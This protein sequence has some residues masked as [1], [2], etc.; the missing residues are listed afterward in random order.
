[1]ELPGFARS[2]HKDLIVA[3]EEKP[4]VTD[5]KVPDIMKAVSKFYSAEM[6]RF[7]RN[8]GDSQLFLC[9]L[10]AEEL[11][12][13]EEVCDAAVGG[14]RLSEAN[15]GAQMYLSAMTFGGK[16]QAANFLK[17]LRAMQVPRDVCWVVLLC[18]KK[19]VCQ[20]GALGHCCQVLAFKQ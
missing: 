5:I 1:M 10:H 3:V 11:V 7:F 14:W 6:K 8:K 2:N 19:S 20:F 18:C 9:V 15:A 13:P 17:A 16:L 4:D 12:T